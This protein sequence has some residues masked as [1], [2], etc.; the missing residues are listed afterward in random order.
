MFALKE[1]NKTSLDEKEMAFI[2]DEIQIFTLVAHPNT[3]QMVDVFES[4]R[5]I[6]IVME[7]CGGGEMF[8]YIT[9][10]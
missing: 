8:D 2:R 3:A 6:Y 9:D 1:I 5:F 4:M 10:S 7:L